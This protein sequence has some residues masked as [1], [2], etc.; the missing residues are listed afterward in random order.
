MNA[1]SISDEGSV[2]H[3]HLDETLAPGELRPCWREA[4]ASGVVEEAAFDE[5]EVR[6]AVR[7]AVL[8]SGAPTVRLSS[9]D[10]LH[11]SGLFG[12]LD[13]LN[14]L[15]KRVALVTSGH[16]LADD[17]NVRPFADYLVEFELCMPSCD[18]ALSAQLLGQAVFDDLEAGMRNLQ[19]FAYR[20]SVTVP[21]VSANVHTMAATVIHVGRAYTRRQ[22]RV[23]VFSPTPDA[24]APWSHQVPDYDAVAKQLQIIDKHGFKPKPRVVLAGVPP[25]LVPFERLEALDLVVDPPPSAA[26]DITTPSD[27][28][29]AHH[30]PLEVERATLVQRRAWLATP[31]DQRETYR[32]DPRDRFDAAIS[33]VLVR[34]GHPVFLAIEPRVSGRPYLVGN[35]RYGVCVYGRFPEEDL[36]RRFVKLCKLMY[37]KE[38]GEP[39][40]T[41]RL[42]AAAHVLRRSMKK[43]HVDQLPVKLMEEG[44]S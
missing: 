23:E 2:L 36:Q 12:L 3:V 26:S 25:G 21:V 8:A 10:I 11:Y 38:Q 37:A 9:G 42:R 41:A 5:Q 17:R 28:Y 29:L 39:V 13:D 7:A 22:V 1:V 24:P 14:A 44:D 30:Q 16:K 6:D 19:A 15:H 35:D 32:G 18:A 31:H 4:W 27:V 40:D 43:K 33:V 34:P 20:F